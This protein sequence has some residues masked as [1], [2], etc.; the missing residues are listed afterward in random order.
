MIIIFTHCVVNYNTP[1]GDAP[2]VTRLTA[3]ETRPP[4]VDALPEEITSASA[5]LVYLYL[6]RAGPT[7]VS[8]LSAALDMRKL[9]LYSVLGALVDQGLVD[10]D[11]ETYAL[12]V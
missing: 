10:R 9:A 4:S 12:S 3:P 1:A 7:T 6:D 2:H 11:G 5:K 8:E